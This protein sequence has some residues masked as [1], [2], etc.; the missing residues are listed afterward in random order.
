[1]EIVTGKSKSGKE[2]FA[3]VE[4]TTTITTKDHHFSHQPTQFGVNFQPL[5]SI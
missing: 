1:M 2:V 4:L 3:F 5:S